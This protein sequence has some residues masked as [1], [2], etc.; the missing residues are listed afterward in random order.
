MLACAVPAEASPLC[1]TLSV[2]LSGAQSYALNPAN[3]EIA[4]LIVAQSTNYYYYWRYFFWDRGFFQPNPE[5][6]MLDAGNRLPTALSAGAA[7][8]P[9][10][11][12]AK[13]NSSGLLFT[14]GP[15]PNSTVGG[16]G[17][18]NKHR[19]N[20]KFGETNYFGYRFRLGGRFHYGWVRIEVTFLKGSKGTTTDVLGYGY[21]TDPDTS[22]AAG[23]CGSEAESASES[24]PSLGQLAFGSNGL[25]MWRVNGANKSK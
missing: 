18:Y 2:T 19:G 21:E 7:I 15:G 1:T 20:F 9:S 5:G 25:S 6:V 22:I 3:Q 24:T 12:F 17:T 4:P 8:G 13:A 10:A 14:Y 16:G 23:N 11:N